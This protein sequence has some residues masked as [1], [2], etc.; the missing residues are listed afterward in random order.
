MKAT[1]GVRSVKKTT[2]QFILDAIKVHGDFYSYPRC[3]YDGACKNVTITCKIH[4]DF[5]LLAQSHTNSGQGCKEC[6]KEKV[7]Q[8]LKHTNEDV[9]KYLLENNI[10]IK[11]IG[12]YESKDKHT[13]F[14]CLVCN[15]I[16][17]KRFGDIKVKNSGCPECASQKWT[18]EEIDEFLIINNRN[19]KRL[20]DYINGD[21][22][23]NC[24]CLLCDNVW[25][26]MPFSILKNNDNA[27]GCPDCSLYKNQK[28]VKN[29]FCEYEIVSEK[30]KIK[31][32]INKRSTLPD[33]YISSM[34]LII[35][36]NGIQHYKI[37]QFGSQTLEKATDSFKR[38]QVRDQQLRIYCAENNINLLEIDGRKYKGEKLIDFLHTYFKI[39]KAA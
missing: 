27:S 39:S 31:L 23:I 2:E 26:V 14:Q 12:E 1:K 25:S 28:I 18:N 5:E 35:E 10:Q 36:Y 37:T 8:A 19:I 9:D 34:N 30:I 6:G 38:Q 16:W 15:H 29:F 11:R 32:P 24:K 13:K 4:G 21:V 22:E 20:D 3:I 7:K 17:D 33:F